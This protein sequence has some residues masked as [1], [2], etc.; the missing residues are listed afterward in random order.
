MAVNPEQLDL[1]C[2][3]IAVMLLAGSSYKRIS[4]E[5]QIPYNRVVRL[6]KNART[7][8]ILTSVKASSIDGIK[9]QIKERLNNMTE[10]ALETLHKHLKDRNLNAAITFFEM[11]GVAKAK[12]DESKDSGIQIN[13][14]LGDVKSPKTILGESHAVQNGQGAE[15]VSTIGTNESI[16]IQPFEDAGP[17]RRAQYDKADLL[18]LGETYEVG[19]DDSIQPPPTEPDTSK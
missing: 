14:N 19:A 5:L 4:E 13:L 10:D 1:L 16:V 15:G 12:D 18:N 3:Q 2:R 7:K 9:R 6:A 8:K 11:V 17:I